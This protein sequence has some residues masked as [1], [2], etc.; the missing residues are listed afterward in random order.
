MRRSALVLMLLL[1]PAPVVQAQDSAQKLY[2]DD[3][4]KG[5]DSL[6]SNRFAQVLADALNGMPFRHA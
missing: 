6:K 3:A 4:V 5:A 1:L 2:E